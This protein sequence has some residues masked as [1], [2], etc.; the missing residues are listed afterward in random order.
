MSTRAKPNI[1]FVHGIWADGSSFAKVIPMLR[2]GRARTVQ[3]DL[4]RFVAKRMGAATTEI[5]SSRVPM[6]SEP[7]PVVDVIR[8]AATAVKYS[9]AVDKHSQGYSYA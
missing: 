2:V 4:Q 3:P 7:G 9:E 8:K 1:V 6:L 5:E